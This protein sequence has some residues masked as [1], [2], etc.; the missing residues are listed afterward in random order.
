[1][2][3]RRVRLAAIDAILLAAAVVVFGVAS[4][5]FVGTVKGYDGWGHLSKVVLVLRNFPSLDWNSEWY[6]GSPFFLGGYPP[7]FYLSASAIANVG[8]D[9]PAAM[10]LLMIASY[11]SMIWSAHA[12]VRMTA[13]S[14]VAGLAAAGLL[15]ASPAWWTPLVTAGLYTR[16]FGMAFLSLAVYFAL[17]YLRA[18]SRSRYFALAAAVF[19]ALGSHVVLGALAVVT[20]AV[21]LMLVPMPGQAARPLR[22]AMLLPPVLLSAYFYLPL[23]LYGEAATQLTA[24]YPRLGIAEVATSL[25]PVL[26]ATIVFG[27]AWITC[28]KRVDVAT[29]RLATA[30]VLIIAL[31]ALYALAPLPRVAGLRS[32]DMLFF[33]AW[34][35][36]L[37]AGLAVGSIR[38]PA[39]GSL[40]FAARASVLAAVAAVGL[41]ELPAVA[42]SVV[43]NPAEPQKVTQG[44][45]TVP[46]SD[47][48]RVA[49][50]T[51]NLSVWL[52]AV[53]Q[54]PQTRGY[55]AIPQVLNP[56]SQ[57]WF[58]TT[59]W[60]GNTSEEER[61]FL[62]DW[63][64]VRWIY[65]P[66]PYMATTA[67]VVPRLLAR[68]DLYATVNSGAGA[69]SLTFEYLHAVPIATATSAP[70]VLVIADEQDYNILFRDLA[71]GG[72]GSE[73]LIP[74]KGGPYVDDY[75]AQ[76]LA[77]FDA[78]VMYGGRLHD[79]AKA[80]RLLSAY[81]SEGGGLIV[82]A[83]LPVSVAGGDFNPVASVNAVQIRD[84]WSFRALS[85]PV[86]DGID[87]TRFGP[88]AY[89][90]GPW[91]VEEAAS[92]RGASEPVLWA[93]IQ[94]LVVTSQVGRGRVVWSG[95]NL[96][97]HADEYR[98]AEES[99]FLEAAIRWAG[100][101]GG[102]AVPLYSVHSEGPEQTTVSIQGSARGVLFKESFFNRWHAYVGGREVKVYPA[103]PGFMY[104]WLPES[105]GPAV[106]V[107][108]RYEKSL[109]DWAGIALSGASLF[110]VLGW[111][112]FWRRLG[113]ERLQ[114]LVGR[115]TEEDA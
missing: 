108:W 34:F 71:Y 107:V 85:S 77:R 61:T 1:M 87:F 11:V 89:H 54:T 109:V 28:R 93:G 37:L 66:A 7:L 81:V 58:D 41:V 39:V 99:R 70:V 97:Y 20:V 38:I 90:G 55:A 49:S 114:G 95:L 48:Y 33:I 96:P 47:A 24:T 65:V 112:L 19:G 23:A 12:T 46:T 3:S 30:V 15:L 69:A 79:A 22:A 29:M 64:A 36:A 56:D 32:A 9:A 83:G 94:P 52:N 74:I 84:G 68:P 45:A 76:D 98:N 57:Y 2:T 63:Y 92:L 13:S 50:R 104:A 21:V 73:Q 43:A 62:F 42:A 101:G 88:P 10:N 86:T 100:R 35:L 105:A 106:S 44:W 82:D 25:V 16:V 18:P 17:L 51:D 78:V 26:P 113:R 53:Y 115:F 72:F 67:G 91:T 4:G 110:A 103:G 14:R 6:S 111:P 8:F 40:S 80:R 31:L 59:A 60:D 5:A 27:L 75:S 102:D